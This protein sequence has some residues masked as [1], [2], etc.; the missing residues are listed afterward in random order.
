M[1]AARDAAIRE[2][3][4]AGESYTAIAADYGL[5]RQRVCDICRGTVPSPGSKEDTKLYRFLTE[6]CAFLT[7][8][9]KKSKVPLLA[10][11]LVW[12]AWS[13][14]GHGGYPTMDF[15]ISMSERQILLI[16]KAGTAVCA[17]LK[18]AQSKLG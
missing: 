17:F 13:K 8:N 16:P 10:Y 3:R 5:S 11:D 4:A 2:R 1:D 7:A 14:Q 12:W 9:G 18:K 15:F 6:E